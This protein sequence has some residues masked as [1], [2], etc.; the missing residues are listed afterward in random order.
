MS[1][2]ITEL[3][4]E[5]TK[6][7]LSADT[8]K[9]IESTFNESVEQKV[10]LQV[11]QALTA[12]DSD[13]ALKL[14][15]LLEAIDID[16]TNKLKNIVT[17]IE[18]DHVSKLKKIVEKY[19]GNLTKGAGKFKDTLVEQ[20]SNYLELYIDDK[21]PMSTIQEAVNNKRALGLLNELRSTLAVDKALVSNSIR[22]AVIDGKKRIDES[23]KQLTETSSKVEG[24]TREL[25]STK[26]KLLLEQKV[27]GL[28]AEKQEYV[29]KMLNGK[30]QQFITENFKYTLDLYKR[31]KET[32][33]EKLK[34]EAT[35]DS[36]TVT[37]GVDRIVIEESKEKETEQ[38]EYNTGSYLKELGK[39]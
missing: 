5:A 13:Y 31:D 39:Y 20:I 17:I 7:I 23:T 4:K 25:E 6:D 33:V 10:T 18:K 22:S 32:R 12:Q 37:E 35:A 2:N 15:K 28:D 27:S 9:Q 34:N 8:L 36:V 21:L 11:E 30:S 19:N 29:R 1:K 16:H 3:L 26:A 38:D 14:E 24:L